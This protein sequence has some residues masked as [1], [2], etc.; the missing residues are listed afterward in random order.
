MAARPPA[1]PAIRVGS[2]GD[3][4]AHELRVRIIRG[5]IEPGTHLVE[6]ALAAEFDVSRGPIRDAL[7][8]LETEGLVRSQRRGV[9]V[10]GFTENDVRELYSLRQAIEELSLRHAAGR[11]CTAA[12]PH[13]ALMR[14]AADAGDQ[15]AFARADLDFHTALY[16]IA[17]HRRLLAMWQ[18]LRPVF[19][20]ML[21]VTNEQDRDLHP[22][23]EDHAQLLDAIREDETE[24]ALAILRDHL[25]GSRRRMQ[26]ALGA[27]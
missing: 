16:E 1:A 7:K 4:V 5:D 3:R 22:A 9:L 21:D 26:A 14:Q 6:D 24:R 20:V 25:D 13:V 18:Q 19:A 12:A 17:G 10:P 23:A 15:H 8:A 2:L 27:R 11:D